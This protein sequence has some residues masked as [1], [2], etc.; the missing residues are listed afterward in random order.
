ML[1]LAKA[2]LAMVKTVGMFQRW[3]MNF[4]TLENIFPRYWFVDWAQH[5]RV[6]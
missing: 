3:G 2:C 5:R 4:P 6:L 1:R